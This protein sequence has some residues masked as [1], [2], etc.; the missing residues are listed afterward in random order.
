MSSFF[1]QRF[2]KDFG[3]NE[4][5]WLKNYETQILPFF[6]K[7]KKPEFMPRNGW[8]QAKLLTEELWPA[9]A[10]PE[11]I[12][13]FLNY[14]AARVH[15]QKKKI[16]AKRNSNSSE[17]G[18]GIMEKFAHEDR[19]SLFRNPCPLQEQ[20]LLAVA[21]ILKTE[22]MFHLRKGQ[23]PCWP[24]SLEAQ[25]FARLCNKAIL[26]HFPKCRTECATN[27]F[28]MRDK[29]TIA[30]SNELVVM[31]QTG[32]GSVEDWLQGLR[33]EDDAQEDRGALPS[34]TH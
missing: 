12:A 19:A 16:W 29:A 11:D 24:T 26:E 14:A 15:G 10:R 13:T 34:K 28:T 7:R 18:V 30:L 33:Q 31:I 4:T 21:S 20:D 8:L 2:Y 22:N 1:P 27:P 32:N 5:K 6:I 9:N 25:G 23:C 3:L 17:P